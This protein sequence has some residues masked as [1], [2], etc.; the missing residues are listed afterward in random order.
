MRPGARWWPTR[1]RRL[2]GVILA[3]AWSAAAALGVVVLG[4]CGYEIRWK[5]AR[6]NSDVA[7][8]QKVLDQLSSLES[9][10]AASA[11]RFGPRDTPR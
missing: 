5:L 10:L 4:F 6:L 3:I 9:D 7:R 1:A 8:L 2:H 11:A